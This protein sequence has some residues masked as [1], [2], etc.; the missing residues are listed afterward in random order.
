MGTV[1]IKEVEILKTNFVGTWYENREN[2]KYQN[3]F[4]NK[5][6][7]FM[8]T[9]YCSKDELKLDEYI[10]TKKW[11]PMFC[12][13]LESLP[14][15]NNKIALRISAPIWPDHLLRVYQHITDEDSEHRFYIPEVKYLEGGPGYVHG[16]AAMEY[17]KRCVRKMISDKKIDFESQIGMYGAIVPDEL[18]VKYLTINMHNNETALKAIE[19]SLLIF[20]TIGHF[21]GLTIITD[22]LTLADICS[23]LKK[24]LAGKG[25]IQRDSDSG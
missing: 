23:K 1:I 4:S 20:R 14:S 13:I 6:H 10:P 17:N 18:I 2:P 9:P 12:D 8:I 19:E 22:K 7:A 5:I 25:I 11:R 24:A 15:P 3:M 21:E 16:E